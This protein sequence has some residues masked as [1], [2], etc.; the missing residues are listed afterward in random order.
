M[1]G[2][3]LGR[4]TRSLGGAFTALFLSFGVGGPA[5]PV[6]ASQVAPTTTLTDKRNYWG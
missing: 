1:A 6:S 4:R 3:A 5:W 2:A